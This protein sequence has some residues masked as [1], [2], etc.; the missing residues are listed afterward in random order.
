[1]VDDMMFEEYASIVNEIVTSR[2]LKLC[3]IQA[4]IFRLLNDFECEAGI[5]VLEMEKLCLL[6]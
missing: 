2:F 6:N 3:M 4:I 5:Q 1:M